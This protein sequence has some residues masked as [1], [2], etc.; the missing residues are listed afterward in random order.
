[1]RRCGRFLKHNR[2]F[3]DGYCPHEEEQTD[4][5]LVNEDGVLIKRDTCPPTDR[6]LGGSVR[7][8][9]KQKASL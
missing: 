7:W 2:K 9:T 6:S 4:E 5:E 8:V 3:Q 1:L